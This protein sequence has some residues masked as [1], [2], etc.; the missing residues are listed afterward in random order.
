M[1]MVRNDETPVTDEGFG[2][3]GA[4]RA[5]TVDLLHAMQALFQLSYSPRTT[6]KVP[7]TG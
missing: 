5:R 4:R 7:R 6:F 2:S 3:D 1:G